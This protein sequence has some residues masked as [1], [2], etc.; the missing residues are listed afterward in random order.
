MGK[1][2]VTR[3][4]AGAAPKGTTTAQKAAVKKGV[5]HDKT[6]DDAGRQSPEPKDVSLSKKGGAKIPE[7]LNN[8]ARGD[9]TTPVKG[10]RRKT[11]EW[12]EDGL[13]REFAIKAIMLLREAGGELDST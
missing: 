5:P 13:L 8:A 6:A 12:A 9:A 10:R 3:T 11:D 4:A 2:N 7:K 1:E